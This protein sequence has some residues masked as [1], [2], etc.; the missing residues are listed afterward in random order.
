MY[1]AA[2]GSDRPVGRE[3]FL[4]VSG[5]AERRDGRV[6]AERLLEALAAERFDVGEG[7]SIRLTGWV[8]WAPYPWDVNDPHSS[9]YEEVLRLADRALYAA[10]AG[11]RNRSVAAKTADAQEQAADRDG[12]LPYRL[13]T[14]PRP[15][16]PLVS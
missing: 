4:L 2:V 13:E 1:R 15:D 16:H 12:A 11:G 14:T 8:G 7:R 5:D 3:E 10:K 6:L 9:S